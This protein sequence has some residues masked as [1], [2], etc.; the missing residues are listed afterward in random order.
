MS[1][2]VILV[3]AVW[4]IPGYE[5]GGSVVSI[6]NIVN[7]LKECF[8]F[9]IVTM[10]CNSSGLPYPGIK[11]N[12]WNR[13][14]NADVYYCSSF[15][16]AL[17]NL[18]SLVS[19]MSFDILYLNSFFQPVFT[20]FPLL[21]QRMHL[22]DNVP[23]VLAPRGEFSEGAM[24]IE[25][26]KKSLF[27]DIA[28]RI[29]LYESITW[30]ASSSQE[31]K[32]IRQVL[33]DKKNIVV[34]PDLSA[35]AET[36]VAKI[37]NREKTTNYLHIVFLSRISRKKNLD[38]ALRILMNVQGNVDFDIF[39]PIEDK[40][41]WNECENVIQELPDNIH[42]HYQG[43]VKHEDVQMIFSQYHLFLFP[44]LGENF[45]HVILE[46]LLSGCPVLISDQTPW[47]DIRAAEAGWD[48][49]LKD[50]DAFQK[51]IDSLCDLTQ[52]EFNVLSNNAAAYG[53]AYIQD[54]SVQDA[55]FHLF[56]DLLPKWND[57]SS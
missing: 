54:E 17:W 29:K 9:K 33:P 41:Y 22:I 19:K 15:P 27:I 8:E 56:M 4:Y 21:L 1:K 10:G 51:V 53:N 55:N 7:A 13:I 34:A 25:S 47:R 30:Q 32:D 39:G 20:T 48:I 44:T 40:A 49:P 28:S 37:N 46:S 14:E 57:K 45:G 11:M 5:M 6:E 24:K 38:S 42:A 31:E 36:K 16:R 23:V 2:P 26:R 35:W 52:K 3:I 18:R 50:F 12:C 43:E